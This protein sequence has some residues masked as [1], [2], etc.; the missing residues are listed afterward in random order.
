V[1][2]R[3]VRIQLA[4]VYGVLSLLAVGV[5]AFVAIRV[6]TS[7]IIDSAE[8]EGED[9][10]AEALQ[11]EEPSNT[12]YVNID[13]DWTSAYG[14]TWVEPPLIT[15]A[16]EAL[17]FGDNHHRF[18][19]DGEWLAT[20]RAV[21][22]S[23]AIIAV[24]EFS[25]F[26]GDASSLRWRI[27]L[28]ALAL[29]GASTAVGWLIAGRSLRPTRTVLAQ[30]RDFIAD[31]AHELRTP[32]AVIQ[33]SASHAL[34][35]DRPAAEYRESLHEI[36][37]ATERATTGVNELLEFARLESGQA[38]PRLA[39][40]RLDL[41]AEEIAASIRV[42]GVVVSASAET[43]VVV[44]AD[45]GLLRQAVDTVVR[46]AAA[47]A[48]TVQLNVEEA[49]GMGL[50]IVRDDGPGFDTAVIDEVFERFRRGD[51]K[52]SSGLGMAIAKKVLEV[53]GGDVQAANADEGG[54]VVTV[55]VPTSHRFDR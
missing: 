25:E 15:I 21:N 2:L 54:A 36:Q 11:N 26:Q 35:R 23:E 14:E 10:I 12:W 32:L 55:S 19:Q 47:R 5:L 46:N 18:S 30:Q 3:R 37:V 22:D 13:D 29:S 42:D 45:Y 20:A 9:V 51:R 41:L 16:R 27:V 8:R 43:A 44:D 17:W 52:G 7:R 31:A 48:A 28:A 40:L 33:A 34:G 53:H 4:A 50:I 24:I 49:E 6:G 38:L 39:P 1:N